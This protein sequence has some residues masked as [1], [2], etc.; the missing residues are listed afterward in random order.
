MN[1][2]GTMLNEFDPQQWVWWG[3]A[4]ILGEP[5]R[6]M[7]SFSGQVE[8]CNSGSGNGVVVFKIGEA[9]NG[10]ISVEEKTFFGSNYNFDN[11]IG[12]ATTAISFYK[13]Q[14]S[15]CRL[16]VDAWS[17]VGI[18]CGVVKDIRVLTG[19]LVW[20]L[21]GGFGGDEL[22]RLGIQTRS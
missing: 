16:A 13:S 15:A 8:K 9:L 17:H 12:S 7:I 21:N 2:F 11:L 20:V 19:K 6:F 4:A 10:H 3:R 5:S 14:L 22:R 18:Q 1:A